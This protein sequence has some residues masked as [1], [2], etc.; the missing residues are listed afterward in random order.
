VKYFVDFA[1]T[2]FFVQEGM[3]VKNSNRRK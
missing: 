1:P 2:Q 3:F